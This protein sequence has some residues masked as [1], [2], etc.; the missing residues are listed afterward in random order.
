MKPLY[1]DNTYEIKLD[2][3]HG[4]YHLFPVP[5]R[6]EL[7]EYYDKEF[8]SAN[9]AK[10]I[11]DSAKAVQEEE[12][13]FVT[14]Q[15]EDV[16]EILEKEAPGK[17]IIDIGCGY[18]NFMKYCKAKGFDVFGLDPSSD[19]I[20]NARGMGMTVIEAD[21][22]DLKK[23]VDTKYH[24][25]V[26]LNVFE[27][28]R[29]PYTTL[30]DIR[31]HILEDGGVLV[32]KVP[33]EFNALQTIANQAYDLKSWWVSAPQHI[34]Y[35]TI[36]HLVQ[37]LE[38]NGFSVFLKEATFPLEMFILFGEQYVGNPEVGKAIHNKRVLFD[39]TLHRYDNAFRH[40]LYRTFAESGIGREVVVYAKKKM[41]A[42]S[43]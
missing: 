32:I 16:V 27:H 40:Q 43:T 29:E 10:Q 37:L 2:E 7:K 35:F 1:R 15:Y 18:G 23:S 41:P 31:D 24:S 34:N 26:L 14:M 9:Y 22:E 42:S 39:T 20:R 4:Y 12:S 11:N 36:P 28:L 33:N 25:A 6:K 30:R 17:R 19:A 3:R 5:T 38:N 13:E 21:I 8:Y